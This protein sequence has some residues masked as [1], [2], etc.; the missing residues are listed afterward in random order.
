[1]SLLSH[2]KIPSVKVGHKS[3]IQQVSEEL[4]QLQTMCYIEL[5]LTFGTGQ[6]IIVNS[7]HPR[8]QHLQRS[9]CLMSVSKSATVKWYCLREFENELSGKF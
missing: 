9:V 7:R 4:S 1:M 6:D 2:E 5:V 3:N 8:S